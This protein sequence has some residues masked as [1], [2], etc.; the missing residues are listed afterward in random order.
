[1][2]HAQSSQ[3]QSPVTVEPFH[4]KEKIINRRSIA[5][6]V[7]SLCAVLF[8]SACAGPRI[9]VD[10]STVYAAS[11]AL[12]GLQELAD[13]QALAEYMATLSPGFVPVERAQKTVPGDFLADRQALADYQAT[14]P[15]LVFADSAP[16]S[17][18]TP[19]MLN[20]RQD[21]ADYQMFISG[22]GQ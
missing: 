10:L 13:R 11:P 9:V 2:F 12:S 3:T 22:Y 4:Q 5:I 20:D 18:T 15:H 7:A 14:L 16:K 19:L 1:M 6:L 21:V 8:F 17:Q